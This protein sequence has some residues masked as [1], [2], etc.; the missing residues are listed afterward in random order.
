MSDEERGHESEAERACWRTVS[1]VSVQQVVAAAEDVV[2]DAWIEDLEKA[3]RLLLDSLEPLWGRARSQPMSSEQ[4]EDL[5]R[6]GR[7]L[8][9]VEAELELVC[10]ASIERSREVQ[11]T[12]AR[13]RSAW[14]AAHDADSAEPR[15]RGSR[16][17]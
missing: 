3:R 11:D 6:L 5:D 7:E 2:A 14:I 12:L 16:D 15:V 10:G 17:T 4:E 9:A 1:E 13:L 8:D